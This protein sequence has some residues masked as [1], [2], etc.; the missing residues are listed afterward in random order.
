MT[1]CT[2]WLTM[3]DRQMQEM[4]AVLSKFSN[5]CRYHILTHEDLVP[6]GHP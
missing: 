6:R 2:A 3:G 5:I 4:R 1:G